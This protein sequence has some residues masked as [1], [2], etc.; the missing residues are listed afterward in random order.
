MRCFAGSTRYSDVQ[1]SLGIATNILKA[2]LDGFVE[3]GIMQRRRY[4]EQPELFEYLLTDKGR[5]LA[6][7]LALTERGD[8]WAAPDGP[9]AQYVHTVCG[10]PVSQK[11]MR[12]DLR[13][14]RR[15]SRGAGLN[16]VRPCLPIASTTESASI[17]PPGVVVKRLSQ[18]ARRRESGAGASAGRATR[19]VARPAPHVCDRGAG[20]ERST[21][22]HS[23]NS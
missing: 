6:P 19:L 23:P 17:C 3:S 9:P 12:T 1:R 11:L 18:N 22:K 7:A 5:D 10:S 15:A 2:R 20:E 8:R 14:R 4:S 13:S 16:P 21:T